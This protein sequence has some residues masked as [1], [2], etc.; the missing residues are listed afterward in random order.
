MSSG[1]DDAGKLLYLHC[2]LGQLFAYYEICFGTTSLMTSAHTCLCIEGSNF[3]TK[4]LHQTIPTHLSLSDTQAC[5]YMQKTQ[6][7]GQGARHQVKIQHGRA[8][9]TGPEASPTS[10]AGLKERDYETMSFSF[11][12]RALF[13]KQSIIDAV[14]TRFCTMP[15]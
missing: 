10:H 4:N 1:R 11:G 14:P 3:K 2:A 13:Q 12:L 8:F 5:A 6:S 7:L 15:G 9:L